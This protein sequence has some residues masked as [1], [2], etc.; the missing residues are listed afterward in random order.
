MFKSKD[1]VHGGVANGGI[2]ILRISVI[3]VLFVVIRS[4]TLRSSLSLVSSVSLLKISMNAPA[5][6]SRAPV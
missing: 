4:A 6:A 3:F 2:A 5:E 1:S